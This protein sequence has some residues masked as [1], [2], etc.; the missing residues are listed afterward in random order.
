M[1]PWEARVRQHAKN[2]CETYKAAGKPN[3]PGFVYHFTDIR[4]AASILTSGRIYSRKTAV[5]KGL[6]TV[7]NADPSVIGDTNQAFFDFVRLYFRPRTPTQYCNEGIR[8]P[9][10]IKRNAHCPVPVFFLFDVVDVLCRPNVLV[11]DRS[12]GHDDA[13]CGRTLE[14]FDSIPFADVFH[15]GP[16]YGR[17][18]IITRRHAEILVPHELEVSAV[19]AIVCRSE[20]EK[21]TL[22]HLVPRAEIASLVY[23]FGSELFQREWFYIEDAH[24]EREILVVRIHRATP[25]Q[26]RTHGLR[27]TMAAVERDTGQQWS[28]HG[29][30]QATELRLSFP[31]PIGRADVTI[32]AE[33]QLAFRNTL[34][35]CDDA[36]F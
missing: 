26:A 31:K 15:E 4:N 23:V 21:Q 29:E 17:R 1:E 34:P 16:L 9:Q 14:L 27:L 8:P 2:W 18:E 30:H 6:M 20:A 12:V 19:R 36:P 24:S 22:L 33:G 11:S 13:R 3:I 5:A 28:W 10:H 25:W 35:F 7:D 32:Y